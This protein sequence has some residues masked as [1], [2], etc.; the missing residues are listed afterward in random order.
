[1]DAR[2]DRGTPGV[3]TDSRIYTSSLGLRVCP[4][5]LSR[6][7]VPSIPAV[8][9]PPIPRQAAPVADSPNLSFSPRHVGGETPFGRAVDPR[10]LNSSFDTGGGL[11]AGAV[12]DTMEVPR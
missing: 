10:A 1:M 6:A 7:L 8:P 2:A 11:A 3:P 12:A 5:D 4:P 9:A